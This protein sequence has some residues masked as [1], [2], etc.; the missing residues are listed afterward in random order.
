MYANAHIDPEKTPAFTAEDFMPGANREARLAEAKRE[1]EAAQFA[2]AA[3]FMRMK[4]GTVS[5]DAGDEIPD[6][7]KGPYRGQA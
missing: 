1:T 3:A 6:W 4:S 2:Q 5:V 7:A